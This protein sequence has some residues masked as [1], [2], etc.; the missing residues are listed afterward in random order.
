LAQELFEG[1]IPLAEKFGVTIAG[2]DTNS[3]PGGL[4]VSITLVGEP[5]S[6]GPLMRSGA[7]PGD[8]I[9]VTGAFGGSILGKH[10]D[11]E[12]RV[13]E[14]LWLKQH[15]P[16][17]AGLDV[18]D[19]LSL[20]LSRLAAES[21]C[22]AEIHLAQ[23]PL[24]PAAHELAAQRRDGATALDHALGDGEDFELV[25]AVPPAAADEMLAR[26]PLDCGLACIGQF[27]AEKGLW[28]IDSAGA[29]T[30]LA[31]RGYQHE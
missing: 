24:A 23:V 17:H 3:W 16:I 1:M 30:P 20:D 5:T 27:V 28:Q 22:G 7:L 18:S 21:G 4:V 2:G 13:A 14:A 10:F 6:H 29:R 19:G 25:L 26:Q 8:R 15:Y 9:L 12:P 31:P 11:F